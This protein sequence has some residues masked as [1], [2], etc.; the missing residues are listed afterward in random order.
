MNSIFCKSLEKELLQKLQS[1]NII[2]IDYAK[3]HNVEIDKNPIDIL[4]T[5]CP[6]NSDFRNKVL[7][8]TK[9]DEHKNIIL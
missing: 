1:P 2:I 7:Q 9:M 3:N 5:G 6:N 4:W 8:L